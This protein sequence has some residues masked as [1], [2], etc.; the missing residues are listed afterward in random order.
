MTKL[1][2]TANRHIQEAPGAVR[3]EPLHSRMELLTG[4]GLA[5]CLPP[6]RIKGAITHLIA[7]GAMLLTAATTARRTIFFNVSSQRCATGKQARPFSGLI[8]TVAASVSKQK[9]STSKSMRVE[10]RT[11]AHGPCLGVIDAA[12]MRQLHFG[13]SARLSQSDDDTTP[14]RPP[15]AFPPF[16]AEY[17]FQMVNYAYGPKN[18][19]V[20]PT[21]GEHSTSGQMLLRL[22]SRQGEPFALTLEQ[23]DHPAKMD[24]CHFHELQHF[25]RHNNLFYI[26]YLP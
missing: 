16:L 3:V 25:R 18:E 11:L 19:A 22:Y 9:D 7:K 20:T 13:S 12:R 2:K 17:I 23:R 14:E 10:S 24:Q 21:V 4:T 15:W 26:S 6:P 5:W 1:S 8:H